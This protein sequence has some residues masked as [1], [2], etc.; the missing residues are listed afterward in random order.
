M[1]L[2]WYL[3]IVSEDLT[4]YEFTDATFLVTCENLMV[5]RNY[6]LP[7]FSKSAEHPDYENIVIFKDGMAKIVEYEWHDEI[8]DYLPLDD[9]SGP[10][11]NMYVP[12]LHIK[13]LKATWEE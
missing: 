8:D 6:F 7:E 9:Y 5:F 3:R 11:Y 1:K 4:V 2:K 10:E 13:E 12:E